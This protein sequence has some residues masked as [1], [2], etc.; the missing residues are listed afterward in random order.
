MAQRSS[1]PSGVCNSRHMGE[2]APK[3]ES[4]AHR[5]GT[6]FRSRR[7]AA[8]AAHHRGDLAV[9]RVMSAEEPD[10]GN[11][12]VRIWRGPRGG[13]DSGL[14]DNAEC[15]LLDFDEA[16]RHELPNFVARLVDVEV[17]ALRDLCDR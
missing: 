17:H 16:E 3:K 1:Q 10:G 5:V 7:D 4:A 8:D 13:N 11:L 15:L 2:V 12:L 9:T 14:L 6:S